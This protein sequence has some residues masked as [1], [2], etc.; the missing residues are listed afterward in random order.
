MEAEILSETF[1]TIYQMTITSSMMVI[2]ICRFVIPH[3]TLV[4][5]ASLTF[6][7][8]TVPLL[9]DIVSAVL[10]IL[11]PCFMNGGFDCMWKE[12]TVVYPNN[13][14]EGLRKTTK[15]SVSTAGLLAGL[16]ILGL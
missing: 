5:V 10:I 15:T 11:R 6:Q 16:R 9:T 8:L 3:H 13:F 4:D 1:M 12:A 7:W 2:C 14:S